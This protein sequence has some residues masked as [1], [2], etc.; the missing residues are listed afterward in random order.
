MFTIQQIQNAHARVKSGADFPAY[1]QDLKQL[2]VRSFVTFVVD[3][4]TEYWGENNYHIAS[5][6]LYADIVIADETQKEEFV[7]YLKIH[8]QGATDY[9]TFC[10]HCAQTGIV[11]WVV[12]ITKLTCTYY[13]KAG[14][15]IL[16][17]QIPGK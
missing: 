1:I 2:G 8:Q 15:E 9:R 12:D 13:N 3:S 5:S 17:E 7:H 10:S 4:H 11:K 6:R 14:D 16:T